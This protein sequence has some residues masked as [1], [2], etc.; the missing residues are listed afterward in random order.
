MR[1]R[2]K[3]LIGIA[4]GVVVLG[5]AG[6]IGGPVLYANVVN[7]A[8]DAAPTLAPTG[9]ATLDPAQADGDWTSSADSF[10]GYRVHEVLR[11]QDVTVTGRTKDV[12]ARATVAGGSLTGATV[13]VRVASI[14]TPESARDEYF[15]S[16]ALQT[17]R[18]P[19][20]TFRVTDPVDVRAALAG[21][22]R[23]V[24]LRGDLTMHGVTKAVSAD[25]QLGV[26]GSGHVEVAGSVPVTFADYG[27]TAP[28]LG[29]VTVD[30]HGAVE[31]S[32]ELE[33]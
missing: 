23:D 17:D 20:A 6:V 14:S 8:A 29:F 24:T 25:A 3:V 9:G 19:T 32:L 28:D 30:G 33:R 13:T 10:A 16:E 1:R 26:D 2:T 7:G 21:T 27:V 12:E 15:R 5:A 11:G 22:D 31:F 18:F 4:S